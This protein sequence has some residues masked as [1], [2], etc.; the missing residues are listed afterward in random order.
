MN[1]E[2]LVMATLLWA[3]VASVGLVLAALLVL[4]WRS[5]RVAVPLVV[6]PFVFA[7][8]ALARVSDRY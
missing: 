3:L 4:M 2:T 5:R 8:F 1:G 7:P 6:L